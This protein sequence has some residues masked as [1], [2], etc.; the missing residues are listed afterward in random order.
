MNQNHGAGA[1][2]G[3][4]TYAASTD[5]RFAEPRT[6]NHPATTEVTAPATPIRVLLADDHALVRQG[7]RSILNHARDIVVV[8]E[9]SDGETAV[10]RYREHQPDVCLVDIQLP[11]V[12]GLS[13]LAKI[14]FR[15]PLARVVMLTMWDAD[16]YIA[17]AFKAGAAAYVLKDVTPP[18]LVA[19]V[20]A[21]HQ[22]STWVAP[23]I[24]SKLAV[25]MTRID[26]TARELDVLRLLATGAAN[27]EIGAI[28]GISESTVKVHVTR[29]FE[30]LGLTSRTQAVAAA[31][32]QGLVPM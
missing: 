29:L 21:V 13:L 5:Q 26:P 15:N 31:V 24:A 4:P 30:K 1:A 14:R 2:G 22:G 20:R 19:C 27:K 8:A 18:D 7:V 16:D 10:Q 12:D 3:P 32:R 6:H 9:A 17:R 25:R 23:A 28:L 11:I